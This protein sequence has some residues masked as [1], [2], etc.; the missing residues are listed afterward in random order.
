MTTPDTLDDLLAVEARRATD[1]ELAR[2]EE[3]L[4]VERDKQLINRNEELHPGY[5][6]RTTLEE[7]IPGGFGTQTPFFFPEIPY[8]SRRHISNPELRRL[9]VHNA[10]LAPA[11]LLSLT[12]RGHSVESGFI[13][14]ERQWTIENFNRAEND[15]TSTKRTYGRKGHY[16]SGLGP[17]SSMIDMTMQYSPLG[18]T[19]NKYS[20]DVEDWYIPLNRLRHFRGSNIDLRIGGLKYGIWIFKSPKYE[21]LNLLRLPGADNPV[22]VP[23]IVRC[24][25]RFES[26]DEQIEPDI[27]FFGVDTGGRSFL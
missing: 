21:Y 3:A 15:V 9:G 7:L 2:L 5:P 25:F 8:G 11:V 23:R 22:V 6:V 19:G 12:D 26:V 24:T 20:W 27:N 17:S 10:P 1:A 16:T 14:D 18:T 13:A 4:R